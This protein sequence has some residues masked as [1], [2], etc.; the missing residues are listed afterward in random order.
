MV[1]ELWKRSEHLGGYVTQWSAL[2]NLTVQS[3]ERALGFGSG[4]LRQGYAVYG[5]ADE[6]R[7][8]ERNCRQF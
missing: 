4:S 5:L 8:R 6:Q 1:T 3:L 2:K 7:S